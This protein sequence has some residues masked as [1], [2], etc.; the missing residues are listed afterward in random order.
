MPVYLIAHMVRESVFI[1]FTYLSISLCAATLFIIA[2]LAIHPVSR[3]MVDRVSFRMLIYAVF[4]MLVYSVTAIWPLRIANYHTCPIVGAVLLFA[5]HGSSFLSF[6]IGLNLQLV[7][8]HGV[9][10][11]KVEKLY[12]GGSLVLATALGIVCFASKQWTYNPELTIC[13]I[14]DPDPVK[15]LLWE[16]GMQHFWNFLTMAGE[17]VTFTSIVMYMMRLKVSRFFSLMYIESG[18]IPVHSQVFDSG[19]RRT[20][21]SQHDNHANLSASRQYPKPRGPKQY[22]DF[23]LR[24]AL[25]PLLSLVTLGIITIGN[26]YL[27]AR[28]IKNRVST[29]WSL[30]W[31]RG[32]REP[33]DH[34][35][36]TIG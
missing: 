29:R 13:W 5:V 17:L 2:L 18:P 23:I 25:Y 27:A 14:H 10:G 34:S 22:R 3:P 9:D 8:I 26:T 31:T 30:S 4:L 12:V 7:M 11:K 24:I 28:G 35:I 32:S 6:C 1:P 16:I 20:R 19:L 36:D 15:Q 33:S 21:F